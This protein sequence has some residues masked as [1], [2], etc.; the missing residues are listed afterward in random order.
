MIYEKRDVKRE[1]GGGKGN[2]SLGE[3]IKKTA[4]KKKK[5]NCQ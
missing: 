5:S 4:P 2:R 3:R 1:T